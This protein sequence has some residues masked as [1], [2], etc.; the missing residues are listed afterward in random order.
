MMEVAEA[1]TF[2]SREGTSQVQ[3]LRD[4]AKIHTKMTRI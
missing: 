4:P 1:T 3:S 2:Q